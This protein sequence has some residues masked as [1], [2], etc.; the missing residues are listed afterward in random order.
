MRLAANYSIYLYNTASCRHK[1][2]G[3]KRMKNK[4]HMDVFR[5]SRPRKLKQRDV[6]VGG[7]FALVRVFVCK[8]GAS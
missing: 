6:P 7:S 1:V 4:K 5:F 3:L 8:Y 2:I